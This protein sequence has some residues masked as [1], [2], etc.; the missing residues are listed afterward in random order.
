MVVD[1]EEKE[2]PHGAAGSSPVRTVSARNSLEIVADGLMQQIR[3]LELLC[4]NLETVAD[5]LAQEPDRQNCLHIA[6]ALPAAIRDAHRFEETHVFPLLKDAAHEK[7]ETLSRLWLEHIADESYADE[8]AEAL[9]DHIAGRG[10]LD[11]EALGYMLRGF[12]EGLRRH[13]AFEREHVVPI[14]QA[15]RRSPVMRDVEALLA[16]YGRTIPRYTSYPPAPHFQAE[17][18]PDLVPDLIA[19]ARQDGRASIYLHI[20]YCD[21]LCWFCGCHTKQTRRYEPVRAYVDT[22]IREIESFGERA[23]FRAALTALHLGGGS[24]SLLKSEDLARIGTAIRSVF[25]VRPT[26]EIAVEIDPS[27]VTADTLDGLEALGLTRASI[28]VQDFDPAV[29]AAI[30]RPQSFEITAKV[31]A[32]LHE[33]TGC[34][35]NI[36]ALY[37]LPRQTTDRLM[38]TVD[39]VVEIAPQRV[40]LFGYA[41]VPWA[42]THQRM[43]AESDLP[44]RH[45]RLRQARLAAGRLVE[46]GYETIGFDHFARPDDTLAVAARNGRLH[47][48]FQGYT[49]DDAPVLIGFGAS[50]ISRYPG[51]YIQNI[52]PTNNYRAAVAAGH[53]SAGRGYAMTADD[54]MRSEA[55]ETLLC[56]FRVDF[57]ALA[58]RHGPSASD[59]ADE[60][61]AMID[62][63]RFGLASMS[64]TTLEVPDD[65]RSFVRIVAS[66]MDAYGT[67]DET[68]RYSQAV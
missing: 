53:S 48:N 59:L 61:K 12:F 44:G 39:Q 19:A 20:P 26:A 40:A 60:A 8:L 10:R 42:K 23:E 15:H 5:A 37:G 16:V 67:Q 24:P 7:E 33:R 25:D 2:E 29:Q 68:V 30:N 22:L 46:A 38:R 57:D 36:D 65:A 34:T 64:G 35:L 66:W 28:G 52:V 45:E 47:R 41:H 4:D 62:A 17:A 6:R 58:K 3:L 43:I 11:A 32:A 27:D 54:R 13:L 1:I 9:R 49:A 31:A 63:D 14:L 50:A 18:G 21:R 51:G 56:N 55:I